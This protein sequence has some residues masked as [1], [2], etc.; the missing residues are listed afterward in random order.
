M[1]HAA[2]N[3]EK[4]YTTCEAIEEEYNHTEIPHY[5]CGGFYRCDD[6]GV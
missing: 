4:T 1:K 6:S 2:F 3:P 5:Q